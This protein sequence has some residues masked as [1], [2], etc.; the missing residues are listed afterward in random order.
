MEIAGFGALNLDHVYEVDN[1]DRVRQAGFDLYPG[2][3]ISG[4]PEDAARLHELLN[5]QGRLLARSGGG[6]AA[7]TICILSA[8]GHDTAFIG[9]VGSDEAGEFILESMGHV[10]CS[11]VMRQGR[12]GQCI[13]IIEKETMD[14][15]MFVVPGSASPEL[16]ADRINIRHVRM[17]H[18]SSLAMEQG[19]RIQE[20]LAAMLGPGQ[21]LSFD[22]GELYA[23]R[24]M[25]ALSTLF[26]RTNVLFVTKEELKM[27]D[28]RGDGYAVYKSLNQG[29]GAPVMVVK[30]GSRGAAAFI[31]GQDWFQP[32]RH[33]REVVDNTGAGDAFDAGFLHMLLK[34]RP[35]AECLEYAVELAAA[36]L[37]DYGRNWLSDYKQNTDRGIVLP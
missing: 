23:H 22:P 5:S 7:N 8:L 11:M 9:S 36:S 10:D 35:V 14:R 13:V 31:R 21:I 28:H 32:A 33:V 6:S 34:G 24:G 17:L 12:S 1:L 19:P 30:Q 26:S 18:M 3:E 20:E 2:R 4:L 29:M 16:A 25:Q 37:K 15:A 27:L